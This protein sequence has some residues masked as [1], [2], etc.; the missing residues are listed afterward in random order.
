MKTL[1][2]LCIPRKSIFEETKQDVVLDLTDLV[3]DRIDPDIFFEEKNLDS[4]SHIF[5]FVARTKK[6]H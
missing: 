1:F 2:E 6:S 3:Q 5:I 4:L